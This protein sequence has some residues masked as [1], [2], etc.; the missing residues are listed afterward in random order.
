MRPYQYKVWRKDCIG[1]DRSIAGE[2][3]GLDTL[4]SQRQS[5][6]EARIAEVE[7]ISQALRACKV[8]AG[9]SAKALQSEWESM[10]AGTGV[11]L[12][13]WLAWTTC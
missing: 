6:E 3:T 2:V 7:V 9:K 13:K 5:L 4:Q 12:E 8:A 10:C 11:L 1:R